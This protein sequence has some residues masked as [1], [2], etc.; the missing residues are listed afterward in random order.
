MAK[1]GESFLFSFP[2]WVFVNLKDP[3][4][5]V[6]LKKP[7]SLIR[8]YP[9]FRS[10]PA[11][12]LPMPSI[13]P[14]EI[15]FLPGIEVSSPKN[16]KFLTPASFPNL[17]KKKGLK[18]CWDEEFEEGIQNF[19]MDS[20]RIDIIKKEDDLDSSNIIRKWMR[21]LLDNLRFFS[22]QWW[23]GRSTDGIQGLLR[24]TFP[25]N[26]KGV[27][28]E[29]P[30]GF[31]SAYAPEKDIIPI[32][33][34][35]WDAAIRMLETESVPKNH[36]LILQDA[37]Y[38]SSMGDYKRAILDLAICCEES[39]DLAFERIWKKTILIKNIKEEK[40]F[41]VTICPNIWIKI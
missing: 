26:E 11:N 13:N 18:I 37:Q 34:D 19:P 12:F 31:V 28:L 17:D 38:F 39:K 2:F 36:L 23:I 4:K 1:K 7:G 27:P 9:P 8:V 16:H 35:L 41:L 32:G 6:E 25:C 24:N 40:C 20:I 21:Q 15:P 33:K 22:L 29:N 14:N 5:I 30:V 3:P 10:G